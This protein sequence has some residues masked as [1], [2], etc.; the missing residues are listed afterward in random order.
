MA[1][2]SGPD[3]VAEHSCF[4]GQR[5]PESERVALE[6]TLYLYVSTPG[7]RN[8]VSGSGIVLRNSRTPQGHNRIL[9]IRH[10]TQ[11]ALRKHRRIYVLDRFGNILGEARQ[12]PATILSESRLAQEPDSAVRGE[13][14]DNAV[15]LDMQPRTPAYDQISGVDVAPR[16]YRG[17]M[18]AWFTDPGAL[19]PGVSGAALLNEHNQVI[20]IA[21]GTGGGDNLH[22]HAFVTQVSAHDIQKVFERQDSGENTIGSATFFHGSIAAFMPVAGP[23]VQEILHLQPTFAPPENRVH[24]HVFGYPEELCIAYHGQIQTSDPGPM[25]EMVRIMHDLSGL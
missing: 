9:T 4:D 2:Q 10:V 5:V 16:L 25:Q 13:P 18:Y 11:H 7:N 19:M 22:S 15:L 23:G 1:H 24:V 20:G 3:I 8:D 14:G 21:E 6:A 17:I 12:T